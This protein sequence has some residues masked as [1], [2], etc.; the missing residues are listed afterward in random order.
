MKKLVQ[1]KTFD[2]KRALYNINDPQIINC[3][4]EKP[5]KRM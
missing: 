3:N 5:M 1:N 2:E 4:F